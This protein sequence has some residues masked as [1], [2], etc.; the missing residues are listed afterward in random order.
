MYL[1]ILKEILLLWI[2]VA[3]TYK[4]CLKVP[5]IAYLSPTVS[6]DLTTRNTAPPK[7][8]VKL[9]SK[10]YDIKIVQGIISKIF[11]QWMGMLLV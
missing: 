11:K 10:Q 4:T 3:H 2:I 8:V 9:V 5:I 6:V 1:Q 7:I